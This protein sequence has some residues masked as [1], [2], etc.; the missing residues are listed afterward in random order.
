M[1]QITA[2]EFYGMIEKNPNVF[3]HWNTP[4]E[5]IES[6]NC[7]KSPITHLSPLLTFSG[8]DD[9]TSALFTDCPNLKIATG[10]FKNF[11]SFRSDSLEKIENLQVLHGMGTVKAAS[12][13]FC[14]NLQI[15]TGT[16]PGYVDFWRSGIHSIQ[17]LHIE[18]PNFPGYYAQFGDCSNLKTLEGWD[19]SKQIMIEPEKLEAEI[20]RRAALKKFIEETQPEK[21]P[22]L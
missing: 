6:I 7:K 3:E 5:I 12:F 15:A 19:L 10:T 14:P 13:S 17:N 8:N 11:V 22:F 18:K 21:L 1:K 9:G 16:Y 20:K 4:L 2:S